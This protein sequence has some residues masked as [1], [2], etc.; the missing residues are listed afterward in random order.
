MSKVKPV[1]T[2]GNVAAGLIWVRTAL[3]FTNVGILVI[4]LHM[5]KISAQGE[6]HCFSQM[7]SHTIFWFSLKHMILVFVYIN[8]KHWNH[9]HPSTS[10]VVI[11]NSSFHTPSWTRTYWINWSAPTCHFAWSREWLWWVL[12][13][14]SM[15]WV[16]HRHENQRLSVSQMMR[17]LLTQ[18]GRMTHNLSKPD[19]WFRNRLVASS[20]PSRCL[21]QCCLIFN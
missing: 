9:M 19:L 8:Q 17:G 3:I 6:N 18:L 14:N 4:A 2:S 15:N 21:N 16:F 7:L 13:W 11:Y 1:S 10:G 20:S 5:V 12:L